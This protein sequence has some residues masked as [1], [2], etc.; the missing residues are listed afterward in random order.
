M[1]DVKDSKTE[2][3][4]KKEQKPKNLWEVLRFKT[5]F[6]IY[7]YLNVYRERTLAELSELTGKSKSTIHEHIKSL[8]E[9]GFVRETREEDSHSNIK[10]KYFSW[11]KNVDLE[12]CCAEPKKDEILT[13]KKARNKI[14]TLKSFVAYNKNILDNFDKF[15]DTLDNQLNEGETDKVISKIEEVYKTEGNA[16][17]FISIAFYTKENALKMQDEFYD[18]YKEIPDEEK[19]EIGESPY[20]GGMSLF[21]IKLI[22]DYLLENKTK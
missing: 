14:K 15:L 5:K 13:E 7:G 9:W 6:Q 18:L 11:N 10:T 20:F 4:G 21:P 3:S 2:N 19:T 17:P 8:I 16:R 1:S 12:E 22:M